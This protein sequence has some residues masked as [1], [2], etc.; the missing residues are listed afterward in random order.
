LV[1][2]WRAKEQGKKRKN[3]ELA[4]RREEKRREEKRREEKR[5]EEKR[6]EEKR[7]ASEG[8]PYNGGIGIDANAGRNCRGRTG[9]VDAGAPAAFAGD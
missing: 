8:G 2:W 3:K 7:P 1:W 9:G 4:Q 5:R 6:R